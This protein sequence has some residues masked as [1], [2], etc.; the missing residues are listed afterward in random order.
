MLSTSSAFRDV[1][2]FVIHLIDLTIPVL[3]AL[4]LVIF[5]WSA[6]RY[7]TKAGETAGRGPAREA[8][9]WGL[10]ALFVLFSIWGILRLLCSTFLVSSCTAGT[11]S[12]ATGAP[13]NIVPTQ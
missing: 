1:V 9:L 10:V 4:A 8:M 12:S 2:S 11:S 5:L 3:T 6:V 7:V 13:I